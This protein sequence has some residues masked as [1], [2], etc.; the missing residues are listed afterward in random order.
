MG[1]ESVRE[2]VG[3]RKTANLFKKSQADF[4]CPS[5]FEEVKS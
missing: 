1:M 2:G 4:V 5:Q 3:N